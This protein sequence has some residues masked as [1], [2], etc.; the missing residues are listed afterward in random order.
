MQNNKGKGYKEATLQGKISKPY[1]H[2]SWSKLKPIGEEKFDESKNFVMDE[3]T[4][5]EHWHRDIK[6]SHFIFSISWKET[7][8]PPQQVWASLF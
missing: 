3:K 6:K 7:R 5:S 1:W 2:V 4:C 8:W